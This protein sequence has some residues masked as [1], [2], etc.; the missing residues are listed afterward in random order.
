MDDIT[1]GGTGVVYSDPWLTTSLLDDPSC[2]G[3]DCASLAPSNLTASNITNTSVDLSWSGIPNASSYQ[4]WTSVTGVIT[5]GNVTTFN[6]TG[7]TE[8]TTY[9]WSVRSLC[10]GGGSTS[11]VDGTFTTTGTACSDVLE[12]DFNMNVTGITNTSATLNWDAISGSASYQIWTSVTGVVN[13]GNSTSYSLTGLS[14]GTTYGWNVRTLCI[15]GGSSDWASDQFTTTGTACPD[16]T[17]ADFNMSETGITSTTA[18]LNWDPIAGA[19]SY[20]IWTSVTGVVSVGNVTTYNLTGLSEN[21]TYTWSVRTL[22]TGGGSSDWANDQFTTL[23]DFLIAPE[24]TTTVTDQALHS[25]G[26]ENPNV[27]GFRSNT[28]SEL[29]FIA[30]P[31]P[32][33]LGQAVRLQVMGQDRIEDV[34]IVDSK[35]ALMGEIQQSAPTQK[36]SF[37]PVNYNMAS[38]LYM[39][40]VR[41]ESGAIETMKLV[42]Q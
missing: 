13:V 36:L 42:I 21:T 41:L 16:V 39:L 1:E 35:G 26:K 15:G 27:A 22:C 20:Q 25:V 17:A 6:L 2:T 9:D 7:L 37:V 4:I 10:A 32:A 29:T 14:E 30:Y 18:T 11:W 5:V 8:G 33:T 3:V 12:A 28:Q 40:R 31:N 24:I 34:F 38:G 23:P 19:N